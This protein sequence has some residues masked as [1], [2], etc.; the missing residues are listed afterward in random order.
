[1]QYKQYD[2]GSADIKFTWEERWRIATKGKIHLSANAFKHSCN[3]MFNLLVS[4]Q[5]K[6]DEK[7]KNLTTKM[8]E[9]IETK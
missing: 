2:D 9:N 7:V 5:M 3:N 6:F 1:M 4:W 8:G